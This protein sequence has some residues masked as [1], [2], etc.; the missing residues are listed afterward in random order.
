MIAFTVY[1][2]PEPAGSKRGFHRGGRTMIVDANA[3]ARP[4]KA[5][6]TDAA[7]G[8]MNEQVKLLAGPLLVTLR[9]YVQRP[10]GHY[11]ARGLRPSAP[12]H[13][14]VKPDVLK[15]ARAVEDALTGIVYRDDSQIVCEL[16]EKHYGDP[17]RVEITIEPFTTE[18]E[19]AAQRTT[20]TVGRPSA[21]NPATRT[22]DTMNQ[23]NEGTP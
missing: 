23:P 22:G 19:A 3:K 5:L 4:W 12:S 11:G 1:G 21:W 15:L 18:A 10:K 9:F 17:A 20:R 14:T 8:A 13:P 7:I 16:L 2:K 6:V